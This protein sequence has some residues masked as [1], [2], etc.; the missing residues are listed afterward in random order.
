MNA[1]LERTEQKDELKLEEELTSNYWARSSWMKEQLLTP[2]GFCLLALLIL[3]FGFAILGGARMNQFFSSRDRAN[4]NQSPF[5]VSSTLT[6][7]KGTDS[8]SNPSA[9]VPTTSTNTFNQPGFPTSSEPHSLVPA[10]LLNQPASSVTSQPPR[11]SVYTI[12]EPGTV[13]PRLKTVVNQ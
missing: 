3:S 5:G 8:V 12:A 6:S 13:E 9:S 2:G 4:V 1:T 10:P 7:A 11:P